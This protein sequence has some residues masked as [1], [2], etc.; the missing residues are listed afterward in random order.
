ML[1][2]MPDDTNSASK[3]EMLAAVLSFINATPFRPFEIGTTNGKAFSVPHAEFAQV[4]VPGSRVYVDG[5]GGSLT[6]L[7]VSQVSYVTHKTT[8]KSKRAA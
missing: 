2:H 4:S 7:H 3:M 5:P 1:D 8:R 6:I